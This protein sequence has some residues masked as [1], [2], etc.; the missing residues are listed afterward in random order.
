MFPPPTR[1]FLYREGKARAVLV[2]WTTDVMCTGQSRNL[3]L[4]HPMGVK[5]KG[6]GVSRVMRVWAS[7]RVT[8]GWDPFVGI[9]VVARFKIGFSHLY[10]VALPS[11]VAHGICV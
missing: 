8:F 7:L 4:F 9:D 3:V 6:F 2:S 1:T 11:V 5:R 10:T